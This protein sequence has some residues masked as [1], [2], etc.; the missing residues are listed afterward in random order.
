[1]VH[2]SEVGIVGDRIVEGVGLRMAFW[3]GGLRLF[4]RGIRLWVG[5]GLRFLIGG[6][7]VV[8]MVEGIEEGL[9]LKATSVGARC[10]TVEN[11]S[12]A[13][14]KTEAAAKSERLPNLKGPECYGLDSFPL[15]Y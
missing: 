6:V 14:A 12:E 15:Q 8:G 7:I 3:R 9:H 4:G 11:I 10:A 2:E 13:K 5:V 1:M